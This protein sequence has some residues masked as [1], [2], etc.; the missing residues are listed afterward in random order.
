MNLKLSWFAR[1]A[2]LPVEKYFYPDGITATNYFHEQTMLGKMIP[3]TTVVYY[4]PD[5]SRKFC[6]LQTWI[7][8]NCK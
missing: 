4:N 8:S 5:Y 3:F 1:I 2:G 7:C 6:N